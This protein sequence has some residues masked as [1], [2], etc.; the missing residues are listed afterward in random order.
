MEMGDTL[1]LRQKKHNSV[2]SL[3]PLALEKKWDGEA[4]KIFVFFN[5]FYLGYTG[6]GSDF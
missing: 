6:Q 5:F 1:C 3:L 4:K 2:I